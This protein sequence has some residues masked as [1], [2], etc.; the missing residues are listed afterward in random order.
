MVPALRRTVSPTLLPITTFEGMRFLN[1]DDADEM[2]D[3]VM[4]FIQE[5]TDKVERDAQRMLMPQTWQMSLDC[6][7]CDDIELPKF[8]VT[9][10]NFLKYTTGAVLTTWGT[11]NYETDLVSEPARISPVSGTSWPSTD[12][13]LNAVVIEWTAGYTSQSDLTVKRAAAKSAVLLAMKAAYDGCGCSERYWDLITSLR[14]TG[15]VR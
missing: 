8:P 3:E 7:P 9:A 5:A 6:F 2:Q 10:V 4:G 11:S 14:T 15:F 12:S 13:K 1:L